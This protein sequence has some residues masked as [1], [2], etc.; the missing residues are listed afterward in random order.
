MN[1]RR[2]VAPP[3]GGALALV[4]EDAAKLAGIPENQTSLVLSQNKGIVLGRW[5]GRILLEKPTRHA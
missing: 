2:Q 3:P 1:L 5:I 4:T